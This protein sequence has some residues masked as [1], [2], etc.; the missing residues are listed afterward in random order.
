MK[1][2]R[3]SPSSAMMSA[4]QHYSLD[5]ESPSARIR[6]ELQA[7]NRSYLQYVIDDVADATSTAPCFLPT[8]II[9]KLT[10]APEESLVAIAS[11]PF[12]L[13]DLGF[14]EFCLDPNAR[15]SD[16]R[17]SS[18]REISFSH[19]ALFFCWHLANSGDGRVQMHSRL[20]LGMRPPIIQFLRDVSLA[21]LVALYPTL[22]GTIRP[23]WPLHPC[24][25]DDLVG[26]ALGKDLTGLTVT[27]LLG[28]QLLAGDALRSATKSQS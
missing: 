20:W 28:H 8:E 3:Y 16:Q 27:S 23:R 22:N 13:F 11:V 17:I 10:R 5:A 19:T 9:C 4:R 1:V 15:R 25:W 14:D 26:S 21:H 2:D 18:R 6:S 12:S 7:L 24:F